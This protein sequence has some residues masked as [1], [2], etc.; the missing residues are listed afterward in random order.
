MRPTRDEITMLHAHVA[1]KRSTCSRMSVG[2]V[3]VRD[4]RIL[5]T[6]YNGAPAGMPHCNHQCLCH[7]TQLSADRPNHTGICPANPDYGCQIAVHAEANAVAYAARHGVVLDGTELFSTHAPCYAC[8]QLIVNAGI[9]RVSYGLP[10]R[11][12]DGLQLLR[13]ARVEVE[14]YNG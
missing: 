9:M 4:Y 11:K 6:G 12:D 10:Y 5:V 7:R 1:A 8:A 2:V 3:V 14:W 13:S